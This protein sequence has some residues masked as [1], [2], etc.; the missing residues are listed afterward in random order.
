MSRTVSIEGKIHSMLPTNLY[1]ERYDTIDWDNSSD[2]NEDVRNI[3]H[4]KP[5]N[6]RN[7]E[8]L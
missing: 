3:Q 6:N 2:S 1:R 4:T 5:R 8:P 7:G